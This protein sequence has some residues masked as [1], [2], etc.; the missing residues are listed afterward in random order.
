MLFRSADDLVIG[1]DGPEMLLYL[2]TPDFEWGGKVNETPY[3]VAELEDPDGINTV[4]N[5]IGHDLSLCID[6][7]TTYNLN[8]YYIPQAGDY[9]R[10]RVTFSIPELS[11]GKHTLTFRAWDLL[12]QSTTKSLEF[13]VVKGLRPELF[14]ITCSNS[15]ARENTT[16]ILSHDRPDSELDIRI[17][18]LDSL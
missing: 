18:V 16:F 7:K 6:G 10:G 13:E 4:G 3:F 11:E 5:G 9:T 2:N 12:N 17:T 1:G 15:P 14:S 8:D